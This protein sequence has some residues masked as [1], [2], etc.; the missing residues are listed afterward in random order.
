M[1]DPYEK[2][3]EGSLCC[4][5][6]GSVCGCQCQGTNSLL[7]FYNR[8][9]IPGTNATYNTGL[10]GVHCSMARCQA[11]YSYLRSEVLDCHYCGLPKYHI[12]HSKVTCPNTWHPYRN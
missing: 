11:Y 4:D 7:A 2:A 8:C 9:P 1:S 12:T 6:C 5:K 10:Y 3:Y